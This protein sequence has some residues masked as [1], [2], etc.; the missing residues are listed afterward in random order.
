MRTD[1]AFRPALFLKK[2]NCLIFVGEQLRLAFGIDGAFHAAIIAYSHGSV[3]WIIP[4]IFLQ[5]WRVYPIQSAIIELRDKNRP[6]ERRHPALAG[7]PQA[8]S[9][10]RDILPRYL[11]FEPNQ[12]I[13]LGEKRDFRGIYPCLYIRMPVA[14][15]TSKSP[16][17]AAVPPH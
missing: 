13:D 9:F 3:K 5:S 12:F 15:P 7:Y 14:V 8:K 4:N 17:T 10:K 6:S 2:L 16:D 11:F 1:G